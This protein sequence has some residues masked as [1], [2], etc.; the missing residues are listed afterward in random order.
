MTSEREEAG[1]R[2]YDDLGLAI[3]NINDA[4][5]SFQKSV[6]NANIPLDTA[7][8]MALFTLSQSRDILANCHPLIELHEGI[9]ER[10]EEYRDLISTYADK[11]DSVNPY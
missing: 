7:L 6:D 5:G 2:V 11:I 1:I 10:M 4:I 8:E 3:N 9:P